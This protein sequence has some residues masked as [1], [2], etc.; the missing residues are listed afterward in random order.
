[1]LSFKMITELYPRADT[2]EKAEG[3]ISCSAKQ[4]RMQIRMRG[5][6]QVGAAL[7]DRGF[8]IQH[9]VDHAE[10]SEFTVSWNP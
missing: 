5:P 3:F 6:R 4:G 1:M 7:F 8:H 10:I 9:Y 2:V